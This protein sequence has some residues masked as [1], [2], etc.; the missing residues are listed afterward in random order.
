MSAFLLLASC[1]LLSLGLLASRYKSH[2]TLIFTICR[3]LLC[4]GRR[5]PGLYTG[6]VFPIKLDDLLGP[7]GSSLLTKMLQVGGHLPPGVSVKA[8]SDLNSRP[9]D[10]VK[11]DKAILQVEYDGECNLPT[12]FFVKFN[13]SKLTPMRLLVE[14]TEV[15]KCEAFFYHNMASHISSVF[16]SPKCYFVDFNDIT[17]EFV[18]LSEMVR[19]GEGCTLPMKH[20]IRDET[21]LTEQQMLIKAGAA[22]NAYTM[23]NRLPNTLQRA[24]SFHDTHQQFWAM[25]QLSARFGLHHTMQK[26]VKGKKLNEDFMTWCPPKSLM[27]KECQL[28]TDMPAI[29]TSL[30]ADLSMLGYGHNDLVVD[31]VF[32]QRDARDNLS[33]GAFDWQQSCLNNIGQEWAWNFHFLPPDFLDRHESELIDT[34][35]RTLAEHGVSISKDVFL[36]AYVL[37][38]AQMFVF[39]GGSL[40]LL[41]SKLHARGIYTSLVP[42]DPRCCDNDLDD[43]LRELIVGA[44]MT[45]RTFTNCCNIMRRHDFTAAW[46]RWK[47]N[48][49]A[50]KAE[51]RC[52]ME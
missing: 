5:R 3:L 18:L 12:Q 34:L 24:P 38:T 20:R 10:G 4:R 2:L 32:F 44:E 41:L 40:Q 50:K 11:G 25:I 29:M 21:S 39:G 15:C 6:I 49:N 47:Q 14:T 26:T 16:R 48:Q 1:V 37:G 45:R 23:F 22:L 33:I 28:I 42:E 35:L 51:T 17:G 30:C 31:N 9:R 43:D 8:V 52:K 27:G 13:L 46:D 19:F 36:N 7:G